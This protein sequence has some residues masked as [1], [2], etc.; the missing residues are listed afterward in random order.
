MEKDKEQ[1]VTLKGVAFDLEGTLV[2]VEALHHAAHLRAAADVGVILSWEEAMKLLPHFIGGPDEKVASEIA[3]LAKNEMTVDNILLAKQTYFN[4][5]LGNHDV[6]ARNGTNDFISWTKSL[7]IRIA[8]GTTSSRTQAFYL[9][10]QAGL[11]D[12]FAQ[13]L[14]VTKDDV[15]SPKPSPDIYQ[16]TARRLG[17]TPIN[18]LVIED[19]ATGIK[20][21]RLA[22]S[23]VIAVPT[24]QEESFI[25]SLLN[26]GADEVFSSWNDSRLKSFVSN[27]T[28]G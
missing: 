1:V 27:L 8:I 7:N 18:Q 16:E 28:G 25:K 2:D 5:L 3:Y 23:H 24:I 26:A 11:L 19:S 15:P 6:V 14:I 13:E 17:I 10:R 21:A 22:G 9:M 20:S 12:E 4:K